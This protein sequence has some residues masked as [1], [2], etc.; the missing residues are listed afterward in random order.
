MSNKITRSRTTEQKKK[1][2][3]IILAIIIPLL[4][5]ATTVYAYG[6]KVWN[7]AEKLVD[8]SYVETTRKNERS[9]DKKIDPQKDPISILIMG[10]DDDSERDLGSARTD[11]L[12]LLT[13][14][15]QKNTID[16]VS[17]P[18]DT[19]TE[20]VSKNYNQND[21]IN[22]AYAYGE[23]GAAMDTVENLLNVPIHYSITFNFDSFLEIVDALDGIEVDVPVTFTD[24]NTY[25]TGEVH[26]EKG[27]QTLNGEQALALARTRKIDNDIKRGERQQLVLQAIAQ[28][29]LQLGSISKY[30]DVIQAVSGNMRTNLTFPQMLGI[31][32]SGLDG[33]YTFNSYIFEWTSFDLNGASMVE[34]YSDS[35][36]FVSHRLN[37]ALGLESPDERDEPGYEFV[38]NKIS[39]YGSSNYGGYST[40]QEPE[41]NNYYQPPVN[42]YNNANEQPSTNETAPPE[43]QESVA[44]PEQPVTPPPATNEN[45]SQQDALNENQTSNQSGPESSAE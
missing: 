3:K 2:E 39:Q 12:I 44:I 27:K 18:R 31:A 43:A 10:I 26:L 42:D 13:I 33:G 4:L 21:K 1:R 32:Q 15:P 45:N 40:Y 37:V 22:A 29:A 14:N 24:T 36:D 23:E 16:M 35:I 7:E 30:T 11:A 38:S 25:G 9:D 19:Y 6:W 41:T 17:I 8:D 34:L 20:I 28:K 5:I